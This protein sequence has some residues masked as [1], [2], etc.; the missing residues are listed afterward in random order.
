MTGKPEQKSGMSEKRDD[1]PA[2][3]ECTDGGHRLLLERA[4]DI[5][6]AF[7]DNGVLY[8][9]GMIEQLT[10]YAPEE[11]QNV[12]PLR[13]VHPDD[14]LATHEYCMLRNRGEEAPAGCSFRVLSKEGGEVWVHMKAAVAEWEGVPATL[15]V[16]RDM[17]HQV[18][19]ET[20]LV[21]S[22][23]LEALG[24]LAEGI[25]HDFNNL[26]MGIQGYASLALMGRDAS[27]VVAE[28]IKKIQELVRN[29]VSLTAQLLGFSGTACYDVLP[30]DLNELAAG[31]SLMVERFNREITIHRD[32]WRDLRIVMADRGQLEQVLMNLLVNAGQAMP[33]GGDLFIETANVDFSDDDERIP[34]LGIVPGPYVRLSITD[35]GIGMDESVVRRIFDPFFTTRDGGGGTGLGL[36]SAYGIVRAYGGAIDVTSRPG[37]GSRFDVY[38]PASEQAERK[39]ET[40]SPHRGEETNRATILVVDDEEVVLEVNREL[41]ESCGYRV[42]AASSGR[43]ALEIYSS[44]SEEIDLVLLDLIMPGMSGAETYRGLKEIESEVR[45]ILLSGFSIEGGAMELLKEGCRA[46][47][48]KPFVLENLE[49]KIEEVLGE[50]K[51]A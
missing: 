28:K 12:P 43:E 13:F 20:Q 25:A 48:Q 37:Q 14:R 35:T 30:I 11:L 1:M 21:Q 7:R 10:G 27:P 5:I 26:L 46:F 42:I 40:S 47:V 22:Q 24:T 19:L 34:F 41:L 29:G 9:N 8:V 15:A 45:V 39:E 4:P 17:T 36:P 50:N 23:K 33:G 44:S 51:Q 18:R 16:L 31:T 6:A 3:D 32:L 2:V 49:K 38:L